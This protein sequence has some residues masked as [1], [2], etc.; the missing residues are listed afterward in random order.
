MSLLERL[1]KEKGTEEVDW[2]SAKSRKPLAG[3]RED[4]FLEMKEKI[5]KRIIQEISAD[6]LKDSHDENGRER[7]EKEITNII[8]DILDNEGTNL[9]KGERQ[10][11]ITE[12]MDET[13]GFGPINPLILDS[14]VSEIMV[15][16]PHQVYVEKKASLF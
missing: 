16:G 2:K 4:P 6:V 1:Q 7:L 15:N 3:G 12:I 11:L 13:I 10:K 14:T 8:E 5:H 9:L